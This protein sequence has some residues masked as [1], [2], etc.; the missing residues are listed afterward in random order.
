MKKLLLVF[1]VLLSVHALAD[2]EYIDNDGKAT[3]LDTAKV[4][5]GVSV[6]ASSVNQL[7]GDLKSKLYD[8][9]MTKC[10]TCSKNYIKCSK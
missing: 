4:P 10:V 9:S 8:G 3:K 6:E 2:C 1:C 5:N 7:P